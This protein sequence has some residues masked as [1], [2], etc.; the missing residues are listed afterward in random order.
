MQQQSAQPGAPTLDPA[1]LQLYMSMGYQIPPEMMAAA[2]QQQQ[3]QQP[4]QP[5]QPQQQSQPPAMPSAGFSIGP[6]GLPM[7]HKKPTPNATQPAAPATQPAAPATHPAAP[8][9][10]TT[11]HRYVIGPDGMPRMEAIADEAP[12]AAPDN[13]QYLGAAPLEPQISERDAAM[14]EL[15]RRAEARRGEQQQANQPTQAQKSMQE[16]QQEEAL[17]AQQEALKAH[18]AKYPP[19]NTSKA[20]SNDTWGSV[21]ASGSSTAFGGAFSSSFDTSVDRAFGAGPFGSNSPAVDTSI[22]NMMAALEEVDDSGVDLGEDS[23]S[24]EDALGGLDMGDDSSPPP[25][26]ATLDSSIPSTLI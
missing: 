4:Q 7:N 11:T 18:S 15:R 25:Q 17:A 19:V 10:T 22:A 3:Q 23:F 2:A 20:T 13:N 14:A 8:A 24:M 9:S 16:V 1:V 6:D 26:K 21:G 12:P 5:Q